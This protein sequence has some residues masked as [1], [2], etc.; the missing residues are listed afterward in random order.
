M[1]IWGVS[2]LAIMNSAV[3]K[4]NVRVFARIYV[5]ILGV[6]IL[7]VKLPATLCITF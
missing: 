2:T 3:V 5:Y 1:D 6:F 4:T 7:G